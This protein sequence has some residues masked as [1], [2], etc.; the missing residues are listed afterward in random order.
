MAIPAVKFSRVRITTVVTEPSRNSQASASALVSMR[1]QK[2]HQKFS[3]VPLSGKQ[4]SVKM[5]DS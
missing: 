3:D 4:R 5:R 2:E 1:D